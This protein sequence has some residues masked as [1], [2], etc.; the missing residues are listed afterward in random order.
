MTNPRPS[1]AVVDQLLVHAPLSDVL[2]PGW[3]QLEV[4]GVDRRIVVGPGGL[5]VIVTRAA[6][7][8]PTDNARHTPWNG[9]DRRRA[10]SAAQLT[11]ELVSQLLSSLSDRDLSCQPIVLLDDSDNRL[12]ARLDEVPV[13]HR[14]RL[15]L[16]LAERPTVF[17]PDT[18]ELIRNCATTPRLHSV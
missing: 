18:I 13:L 8:V 11:A 9:V 12:F 16:W 17:G 4:V 1:D 2:P 6:S 5:Y 3:F 14:R 7:A 10:P 15:T